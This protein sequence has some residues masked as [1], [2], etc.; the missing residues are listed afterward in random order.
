MSDGTCGELLRKACSMLKDGKP[1]AE[2]HTVLERIKDSV[3]LG[4]AAL[5]LDEYYWFY[6][7]Y[8]DNCI[9]LGLY[10]D[11][12]YYLRT[13]I[14]LS[15]K[16]QN[17]DELA[18]SV[19]GLMAIMIMDKRFSEAIT[20]GEKY[21][22]TCANSDWVDEIETGLCLAYPA[23]G[24]NRKAQRLANIVIEHKKKNPE[25]YYHPVTCSLYIRSYNFGKC[26]NRLSVLSEWYD[27][28][29][30]VNGC[31]SVTA[32]EVL[33]EKARVVANEKENGV[34]EALILLDRVIPVLEKFGCKYS[35][36]DFPSLITFREQLKISVIEGSVHERKKR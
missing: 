14:I 28:E 1:A 18:Y 4:T 25:V 32:M 36:V 33:A 24:W 8:A 31:N 23:R 22:N 6:S 16:K 10:K 34:S 2:V 30:H 26:R 27:L 13:A 9:D 7:T 21:K 5:A 12:E 17:Y 29:C 15:E 11:A 3:M 20:I 19:S 35:I